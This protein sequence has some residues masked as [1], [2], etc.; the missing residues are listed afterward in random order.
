[1]KHKIGTPSNSKRLLKS[2]CEKDLILEHISMK[3]TTYEIYDVFLYHWLID[4][5]ITI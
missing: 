2:L 1:M 4:K 3:E 5:Y